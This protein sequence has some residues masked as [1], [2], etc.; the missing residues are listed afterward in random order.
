MQER[1]QLNA[2]S[3]WGREQPLSVRGLGSQFREMCLMLYC[4]G[5]PLEGLGKRGTV[6]KLQF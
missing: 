4:K 3:L 1:D 2:G 6:I 5:N